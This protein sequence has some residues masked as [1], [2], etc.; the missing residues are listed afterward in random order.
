[1]LSDKSIRLLRIAEEMKRLKT[2]GRWEDRWLE[3]PF[4]D[5]SKPEKA[6]FYL[7]NRND[8]D[9]MQLANLYH[10][11]SLHAIDSYFN[12]IRTRLNPLDR[13]KK[14]KSNQNRIWSGYQPYNPALVQKLLDIFRVYY[15]FYLKSKV[16]KKTAAMRLGLAKGAIAID[17]I[18]NFKVQQPDWRGP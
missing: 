7:T 17:E 14:S 9:E 18:V 15:N 13:P 10:M 8:L 2:I 6:V 16:D 11:A 5:M 4:Q 12:Q 3:Y 1:M